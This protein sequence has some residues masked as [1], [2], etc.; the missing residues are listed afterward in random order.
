MLDIEEPSRSKKEAR[1][2]HK[3]EKPTVCQMLSVT[4]T[5]VNEIS[6][7]LCKQIMLKYTSLKLGGCVSEIR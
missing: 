5:L 2:E 3:T 6:N 7:V 1:K 4:E